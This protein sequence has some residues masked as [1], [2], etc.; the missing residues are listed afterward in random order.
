MIFVFTLNCHWTMHAISC[1][2]SNSEWEKFRYHSVK[3]CKKCQLQW[4]QLPPPD[5]C[6]VAL[7]SL[8]SN[9]S[10]CTHILG[11]WCSLLAFQHDL[12]QHRSQ[13]IRW[14][15]QGWSVGRRA[16]QQPWKLPCSPRQPLEHLHERRNRHLQSLQVPRTFP[17]TLD[18]QFPGKRSRDQI[19]ELTGTAH[20]G[21]FRTLFGFQRHDGYPKV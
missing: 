18:Y 8:Q 17:P 6:Y 3:Q 13:L 21:R 7:A 4:C 11:I 20:L 15:C 1:S 14:P 9:I 5:N 19:C 10:D 2:C 12:W 16:A